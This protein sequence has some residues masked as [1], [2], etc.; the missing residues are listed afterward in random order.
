MNN[1]RW[2]AGLV[3]DVA[4]ATIAGVQG[5]AVLDLVLTRSGPAAGAW[6]VLD[7]FKVSNSGVFVAT[8]ER[9]ETPQGPV[10]LVPAGTPAVSLQLIN[11]QR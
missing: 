5:F 10:L 1:R 11:N 9:N 7:L 2:I 3:G 8:A 6:H 4:S